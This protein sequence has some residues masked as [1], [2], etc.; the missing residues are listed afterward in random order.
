MLS[1]VDRASRIYSHWAFSIGS[2]I[3][4]QDTDN[5]LRVHVKYKIEYLT[6]KVLITIVNFTKMLPY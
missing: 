3:G 4:L 2:E 5:G 1:L 6:K